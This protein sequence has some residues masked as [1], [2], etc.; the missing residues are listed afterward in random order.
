M[1]AVNHDSLLLLLVLEDLL[2]SLDALL[3]KVGA[4]GSTTEDN[5]AVLVTLG[6]GDSSKTLL[7][8][9][10]E[11]VL[12]SGG[13]NSVNG[14]TKAAVGTVLEANGERKTRGKL[15]VKLRLGGTGTN[16]TNGDTVSKELRRDGVEHLSGNW[17]T[18]A[19][20]VNEK[21][22]R[23]AETLVD[24]EGVVDIGV[25]DETLPAN[26]CSGLLEVGAHHN[27]EIVGESVGDL[28]KS[29]S[30]FL[31]S[32]RVVDG[33]RTD[34]NEK[35]V[36]LAEDDV[37]SILTA[38]DNGVGGLLG[39]RDFGGEKLGRDQRIL[40]EDWSMLVNG[41]DTSMYELRGGRTA[42]MRNGCSQA[43]TGLT[44]LLM[45]GIATLY[46]ESSAQFH[47]SFKNTAIQWQKTN[48][49]CH[50]RQW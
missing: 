13:T 26:G 10:H 16:S 21:L 8:D 30:V 4:L 22:A 6:S 46:H 49:W 33:A 34:D 15:T 2:S 35:S 31:G 50:R 25:V 38:L 47:H 37:G 45:K 12:S 17:E 20:K 29:G 23:N 24:L 1:G 19:G 27:A 43:N 32:S 48:L 41:R 3:V 11:V 18:L 9:T 28:L 40:S 44:S 42:T 5:E 14:N 7:G 36:A 39:E